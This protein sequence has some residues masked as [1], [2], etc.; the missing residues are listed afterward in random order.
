MRDIEFKKEEHDLLTTCYDEKDKY[1]IMIDAG[2]QMVVCREGKPVYILGQGD[3]IE[4]N[5]AKVLRYMEV[6]VSIKK[7]VRVMRK[8][9]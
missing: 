6:K 1:E 2:N 7:E 5:L 4:D 3:S 8:V 9:L